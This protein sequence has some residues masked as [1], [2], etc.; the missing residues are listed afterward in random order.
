MVAVR[1]GSKFG[2]GVLR[3]RDGAAEI[4][5]PGAELDGYVALLSLAIDE[6]RAGLQAD[7]GHGAQRDLGDAA[8]AIG[9]RRRDR[10]VA[11][12]LHAAAARRVQPDHDREVPV[13]AFFVE[14]AGLLTA[15]GGVHRRVNVVRLQAESRGRR[16]VN[17][18]AHRRLAERAQH[19]QVGD[20]RNL[21]HRRLHAIGGLLQDGEVRPKQFDG[22]LALYARRGL[23]DVVF[24]IL[25]EIERDSGKVMA[26]PVVQ[27][28]R[29]LRLG[30]APR[31]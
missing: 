3:R 15:D 26:E 14:R 2:D 18:D 5:A 22:I 31:P 12:G 8:G 24:D 30:D 11:D 7:P 23:F 4:A 17:L 29:Q 25:G 1:Q 10:Q 6:R 21:G 19:L 20:A 27:L 13:T 28:V 16:P 9:R